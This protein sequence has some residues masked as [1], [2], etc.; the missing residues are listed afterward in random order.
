[1]TTATPHHAVSHGQPHRQ[2]RLIPYLPGHR[3]PHHH[4]RPHP[5]ERLFVS[6]AGLDFIFEH[7]AQEGVSN[8]LHWP[9][10]ASG[11]TL[12]PGYD[13]KDRS[14]I[15][16]V[17]DMTAIGLDGT[18]ATKISEAQGLHGA[19]AKDF[20]RSNKHLVDLNKSQQINLLK[21]I[22]PIYEG[23]VKRNIFIYQKQNEFDA[24]VSFCYNP[25]GSFLPVSGAINV[26]KTPHAMNIIRSRSS[27]GGA[28][29]EGLNYR[30]RDEVNLYVNA[31]YGVTHPL[32]R[33]SAHQAGHHKP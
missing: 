11:V 19:K 13:M 26:G 24:L 7:E 8:H 12:G 27:T 20:A 29:S 21:I 33:K 1:M 5:L 25:G 30:R 16:I 32:R 9:G 2:E 31:I 17:A 23:V 15:Q 6:G 14:R 10:G 18:V 28:W 22:I 3:A 4:E